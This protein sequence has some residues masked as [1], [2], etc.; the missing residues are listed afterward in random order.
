MVILM[1]QMRKIG[2]LLVV[3]KD[4]YCPA[5]VRAN[6]ET[7][8]YNSDKKNGELIA[9]DTVDDIIEKVLE[10]G[11]YVEFVDELKVYNH[12]ALIEHYRDD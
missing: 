9:K 6:G 11:G 10:N 5:F 7:V 1:I 4:F 12:I 3:E 8:F 2:Q